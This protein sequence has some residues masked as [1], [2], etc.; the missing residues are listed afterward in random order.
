MNALG[1]HVE[2]YLQSLRLLNFSPLT[3]RTKHYILK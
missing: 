1:E 2:H 3:L